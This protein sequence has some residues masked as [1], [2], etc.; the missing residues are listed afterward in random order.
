MVNAVSLSLNSSVEAEIEKLTVQLDELLKSTKALSHEQLN[1][2]PSDTE[3][4]ILQVF[5]HLITAETHTNMYL[6][7][8]VLAG[9]DLKTAGVGNRIKSAMLRSLMATPFRFKAPAAVNV[10]MNEAYD[11]EALVKEWR[12]QRNELISFLVKADDAMANKLLF[13][14]GSGVRMNLEQMVKWTYVHAERHSRQIERIIKDPKF[15]D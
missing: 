12:Y 15:P 9:K 2:K 4:S 1:F 5:Q 3:W 6:R 11:Y 13:K 7:K 8:K 10:K 14:H